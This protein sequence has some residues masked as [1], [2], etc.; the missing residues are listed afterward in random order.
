MFV[1]FSNSPC[2]QAGDNTMLRELLHPNNIGVG[3]S[4]SLAHAYLEPGMA[5]LPHKLKSSSET[6]FFLKGNGV[7]SI[8]RADYEVSENDTVFVP[9]NTVQVVQNIG[10]ERLEFLCVVSPP[11]AS[12]DEEILG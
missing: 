12:E 6:Y 2:F 3:T 8:D 9:A 10:D 5:S 1:K 7:I 4:F 11:W